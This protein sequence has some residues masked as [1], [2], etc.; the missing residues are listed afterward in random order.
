MSENNVKYIES[1]IEDKT[2]VVQRVDEIDFDEYSPENIDDMGEYIDLRGERA[3]VEKVL[4]RADKPYL[5][6]GVK[7]VA[8]TTLIHAICRDKK[9]A[10]IEFNCGIGTNKSDLQGRLQVD[11]EGSYFQR[12]VLPI[13][14][15][16]ANH[17]GHA[18]FYGDE[19]GALEED[20]QK[21][22]N[23]PLDK[24]NSCSA[25]GKTYRLNP[26]CK[27]A[28]IFTTNPIEYAGVN[29]LTEDLKS[30]LI[31]SV[32][33]YPSSEEVERV[34]DWTD[35]PEDI[36]KNPLLQ[37]SQDTYSLRVKGDL[38]YVLSPRDL[39]QFTE[40]YRDV[41]EDYPD[42]TPS[43]ILEVV[44]K[45]TI[46]IKYTDP[47]ERELVKARAQETFGVSFT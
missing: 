21:W 5:I 6:Y 16:V 38:E 3:R 31:G 47:T 37:F 42:Q 1:S 9:Y 14:F 41:S 12:G 26:N 32:W 10:L 11:Q 35:I 2:G 33:D 23:R 44:I 20:V 34:V 36:V 45:E 40:V 13:A 46:L 28:F 4:E 18:V 43:E 7:G 22:I 19:L 15:E 30:R 24:R 29:N 25:G 17:Y 39:I 8:K 27:L